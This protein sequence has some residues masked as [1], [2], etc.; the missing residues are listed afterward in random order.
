MLL[1]KLTRVEEKN[2]TLEDR[3]TTILS[4]KKSTE[5]RTGQIVEQ[6]APFL[7]E[8]PYNPKQAHFLG[9]PIDYI[10]FADDKVV[11]LEVKSGNAQLSQRQR[12]I[13]S[14]VEAGKVVWEELRVK[15]ITV[16]GQVQ[17][18]PKLPSEKAPD[19]NMPNVQKDI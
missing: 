1:I 16:N 15:G 12:A 18:T 8:F 10:I 19:G 17:E 11:F 7:S 14:L 4:Q 2:K 13:K 5:T 6:M 3:Y 9:M